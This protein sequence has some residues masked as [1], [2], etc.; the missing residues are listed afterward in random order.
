M[1]K[2]TNGKGGVAA[3]IQQQKDADE[4][5]KKTAADNV[6]QIKRKLEAD[7]AIQQE[8][9]QKLNGLASLAG[10]PP[11][12]EQRAGLL[13][14]RL[15]AFFK[16]D[17][18]KWKPQAVKDNRCMAVAYIDARNVMERL[19]E[20]VGPLGW[21]DSY[22]VLPSGNVS[23]RLAVT[24]QGFSVTKS[25][26]GSQSEQPDEGDRFKAA[27]SDAFKRAAVK[28]GIGRYLYSLPRTWVDYDPQKRRIINPPVI[29]AHML[30]GNEGGRVTQKVRDAEKDLVSRRLC[31]E[32]ALFRYAAMSHGEDLDLADQDKVRATVAEFRA[33]CEQ[34]QGDGWFD[35]I[36]QTIMTAH[37]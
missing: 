20:V 6:A 31:K 36:E 10:Q 29:P 9:E 35:E 16:P 17:A 15:G 34:H 8:R 24:C 5:A 26:V 1:A 3:A 28:F 22:E 25:D 14:K 33:L 2:T 30:P 11:L 27:F 7:R 12:A 18:I 37:S 21:Q 19:D 23:C 4:A 13:M 32:K